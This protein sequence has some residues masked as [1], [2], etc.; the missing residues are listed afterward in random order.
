[1]DFFAV[2]DAATRAEIARLEAEIETLAARIEN[3]RKVSL[4]ARIAVGSG[5][6]IFLAGLIGAIYFDIMVVLISITAVIGG[7]VLLGS[8]RT[9]AD[10][11]AEAM[12]KAEAARAALIGSIRLRIVG[13]NDTLH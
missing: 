4:A 7:F 9:T 2:Q 12:A 6:A 13:G 10:E 1:M 8:N 11:T 3:C 5:I